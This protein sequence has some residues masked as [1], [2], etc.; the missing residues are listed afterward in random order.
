MIE[1]A[2]ILLYRRRP[3]IEIFL[4]HMG[5]PIWAKRDAGAW[6]IPK[7]LIGDG[8]DALAAAKREFREETGFR[9]EGEFK[10]LGRFRQNSGKSIS[11][12]AV[13]GDCDP[14]QMVSQTFSMVW[15]PKSGKRQL[16]PEADRGGWF[17]RQSA[18]A[19]IVKGQGPVIAHFFEAARSRNIL[20][21]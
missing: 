3:E 10:P 9:P 14:G 21:G 20:I 5:G 11:I 15:P 4:V 2:G 8:E 1:S 18:L 7:G 19:K 17:D 16:Y 12:W 13:E 6:S